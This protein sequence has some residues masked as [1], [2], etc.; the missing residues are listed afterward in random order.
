MIARIDRDLPLSATTAPPGV[1]GDA[2]SYLTLAVTAGQG[3]YLLEG[4]HVVVQGRERTGPASVHI[5]GRTVVDELDADV[6]VGVHALVAPSVI[7]R[8]RIGAIGSVVETVMALPTLPMA[9]FQW[10]VP[11]GVDLTFTVL[12]GE[13]EIRY[14]VGGPSLRAEPREVDRGVEVLIH[15]EPESWTVVERPQGGLQVHAR[16]AA[17]GPVTLLVSAGTP[18]ITARALN[19]GRHLSAHALR[20]ATDEDPS[21]VDA[22]LPYTGVQEIDLGVGWATV[23]L[24]GALARGTLDADEDWFWSGIGAL[25]SGDPKGALRSATVLRNTPSVSISGLPGAPGP[26]L[27]TLLTGRATLLSG[28][29]AE[30]RRALDLLRSMDVDEIRRGAGPAE[31]AWWSLALSTL[32]DALR[33]AAS[34]EEIQALRSA[35]ARPA[36]RAGRELPMV[37]HGPKVGSPPW[38]HALLRGSGLPVGGGD[39]SPAALAPWAALASGDV[40]GGYGAWRSA[41]GLGLSGGGIPRGSWTPTGTGAASVISTFAFGLLGL[42]PDAP[43]GRIRVA[44]ALPGHL[45]AFRVRGIRVGDA[46]LELAYEKDGGVHRFRLEAYQGRVPPMVILEPLL[47]CAGVAAVRMDGSAAELTH[48]PD[49]ER[50][51]VRIQVPVDGIRVLEVEET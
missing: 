8:E 49:G 4:E 29:E 7:R 50:T 10:S 45:S 11:A 32:A 44:P 33:Y 28:D 26:A 30:S 51:R 5:E 34:Q 41:I 14:R 3:P 20:A 19:A 1:V 15:P 16:V 21:N 36:G 25:A 39:G 13:D 37:G 38:L 17:P 23:R 35:A 48:V 24:R 9:A 46:R 22:V 43:S 42:E 6:G 27:A 47:P 31:W 12:P 2:E 40:D 18:Q